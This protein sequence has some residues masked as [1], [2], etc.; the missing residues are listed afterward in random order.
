MPGL[1]ISHDSS[2]GSLFSIAYNTIGD[3]T[4]IKT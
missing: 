1:K 3:I 4:A 2:H